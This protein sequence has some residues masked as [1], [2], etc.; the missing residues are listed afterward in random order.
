MLEIPKKRTTIR[1]SS[2]IRGEGQRDILEILTFG[3]DGTAMRYVSAT[4]QYQV[5]SGSVIR[6]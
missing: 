6:L 4:P 1:H 2:T 5:I 3:D